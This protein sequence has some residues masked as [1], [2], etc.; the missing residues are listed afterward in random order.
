MT[1]SALAA[2]VLLTS[3]EQRLAELQQRFFYES[4]A[5]LGSV[6]AVEGAPFLAVPELSGLFAEVAEREGIV[7]HC[8]TWQPPGVLGL[9]SN[10][11]PV[12][13]HI[14]DQDHFQAAME[15]A[16]AEGAPEDLLALCRSGEALSVFPTEN[17]FYAAAHASDWRR[18]LWPA[19]ELSGRWRYA[20]GEPTP[21][22][23]PGLDGIA[24]YDA[25]LAA[26][27]AE[28]SVSA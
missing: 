20:V 9:R 11:S 26:A 24:T 17:G 27:G 10:G 3:L 1:T 13:L 23:C 6:L 19:H 18:Y 8:V 2:T 5:A 21:A 14:A 22:Q 28:A 25:F 15:I 12:L 16:A 7:E 4:T